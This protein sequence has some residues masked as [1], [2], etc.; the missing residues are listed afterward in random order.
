MKKIIVLL[1][2]V[3]FSLGGCASQQTSSCHSNDCVSEFTIPTSKSDKD[4]IALKG[5]WTK[6][7]SFED[8]MKILTFKPTNE[9]DGVFLVTPY[10]ADSNTIKARKAKTQKMWDLM[11]KKDIS[12]RKLLLL[13]IELGMNYAG[14]SLLGNS[15]ENKLDLKA[16]PNK[17]G[18]YY[19]LTDKNPNAGKEAGDWKYMTQGEKLLDNGGII[20]FTILHNNGGEYVKKATLDSL[21]KLK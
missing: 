12:N 2:A 3:V 21:N 15:V 13:T 8:G 4:T 18:Y 19:S 17:D 7:E 10:Y 1:F 9:R 20:F 6:K 14:E 5:A 11:Y 16:L